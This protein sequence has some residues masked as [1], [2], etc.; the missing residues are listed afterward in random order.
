MRQKLQIRAKLHGPWPDHPFLQEL[1]VMATILDAH[2]GITELAWQDLVEQR[3]HDAVPRAGALQDNISRP[4]AGARDDR[5][6]KSSPGHQAQQ[7]QAAGVGLRGR[8]RFSPEEGLRQKPGHVPGRLPL[9]QEKSESDHHRTHRGGQDLLGL[10]HGP[11]G[12][13]GRLQRPLLPST[14][15]AQGYIPTLCGKVGKKRLSM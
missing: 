8:Y 12:M 3:R 6:G 11:Q 13:P 1:A 14:Q 7:G 2:P 4:R 5:Q 10:R 9:D 15:P